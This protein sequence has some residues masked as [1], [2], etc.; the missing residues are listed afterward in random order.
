MEKCHGLLS[1][2][3]KSKITIRKNKKTNYC[4]ALPQSSTDCATGAP[5]SDGAHLEEKGTGEIRA[6]VEASARYQNHT[7]GDE[8]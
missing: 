4:N 5:R 7:T 6:S 2:N 3:T 1:L 8:I